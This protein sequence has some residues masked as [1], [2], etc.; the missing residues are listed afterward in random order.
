M[1]VQIN[2]LMHLRVI[3]HCSFQKQS[4]SGI[5]RGCRCHTRTRISSVNIIRRFRLLDEPMTNCRH[6]AGIGCLT[7]AFSY[8]FIYNVRIIISS[9]ND[10]STLVSS[11]RRLTVSARLL[12]K[13]FAN[14][15]AK[16]AMTGYDPRLVKNRS[17]TLRRI[18][19]VHRRKPRTSVRF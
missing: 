7:R 18:V 17:R 10:C 6:W 14:D 13:Q 8:G 4:G 16:S 9:F 1:F 12:M 3:L 2:R 5:S 19:E 15:I 11:S